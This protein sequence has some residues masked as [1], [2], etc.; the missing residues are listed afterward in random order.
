MLDK[1][2]ND[3][4]S[5]ILDKL[6]FD[7]IAHFEKSFKTESFTDESGSRKQWK[8]RVYTTRSKSRGTLE[9]RGYMKKA[10][11][12]RKQ[13]ANKVRVINNA[14]YSEVHNEGDS[15]KVTKKQLAYF[16]FRA[17]SA[18]REDD[19]QFWSNMAR[20]RVGSTV[21]I[22]ERQFM[23]ESKPLVNK[24]KRSILSILNKKAKAS[25][26]SSKVKI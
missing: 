10:F 9:A 15:Y 13:G 17:K 18:I 21:I 16:R 8:K 2:L 4:K 7:S 14:D 5:D 19:A 1:A 6:S 25:S 26:K 20:K 24:H 3:S 12:F 22:P 11:T 23:G